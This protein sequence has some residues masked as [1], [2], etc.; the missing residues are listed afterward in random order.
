M[1]GV[2]GDSDVWERVETME[3]IR[4]VEEE[5]EGSMRANTP[6]SSSTSPSSVT[7][8]YISTLEIANI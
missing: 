8:S 2:R 3:L 6:L 5:C 7:P 1:K 4:V